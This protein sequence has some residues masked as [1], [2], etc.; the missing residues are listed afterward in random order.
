MLRR[1]IPC[2]RFVWRFVVKFVYTKSPFEMPDGKYLAKF[3][4]CTLREPQPGEAPKMGMDGKPMP[5]GMT[6]DFE[7]LS[8]PEEKPDPAN[9]GKRCDKLTGRVPTPK[10]GCGK[11]LAAIA[12]TVLK[13][14]VEVDIANYIGKTYRIT[15]VENRVSESPGPQRDHNHAPISTSGAPI[16]NGSTGP[17][18]EPNGR[19][20]VYDG[21]NAIRNQ[22]TA[23]VEAMIA[24]GAKPASLTIKPAGGLPNLAMTGDKWGF[25][26]PK[27]VADQIPW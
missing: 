15:V 26:V 6:W 5:P 20:D 11:M 14:G 25:G 24:A 16:L 8:G 13:D 22:S 19:W 23:E 2:V 1:G 7:I 10:S 17:V 21:H 4:G 12:D 3:T 18:P 9:V 27:P